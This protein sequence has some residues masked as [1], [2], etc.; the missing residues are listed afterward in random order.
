MVPP[1]TKQYLDGIALEDFF[2][3]I[4]EDIHSKTFI[5]TTKRFECIDFVNPDLDVELKTRN[6]PST[7]FS[8]WLL[9]VCKT[10]KAE[11]ENKETYFYYF[12]KTDKKLFR[13]KYSKELFDTFVR[14]YPFFNPK[15]EHFFI[16]ANCWE[17]VGVY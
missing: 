14:E 15:Q 17:F 10:I 13:M 9:P 1:I 11:K 8:S 3:P 7:D 6:Y 16:P 5:K 2:K 12:W 4:L